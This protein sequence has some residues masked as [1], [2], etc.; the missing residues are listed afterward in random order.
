MET[1]KPNVLVQYG[2]MSG[3]VGLLFF[4]TLYLLGAKSFA[5]PVALLGYFIPIVFAVLACIKAKKNNNGFLEFP[6]ALR[7]SFGVFVISN[8]INTLALY[9]ILNVVD[10]DFRQALNQI[11]MEQTE[12]LLKKFNSSQDTIE[13]TL[14]EMAKSNQYSFGKMALGFAMYCIL[15]FLFSLIIAAIVKK[16]N[17]QEDMPQTL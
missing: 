8:L 3:V 7:T 12:L 5:S 6:K 15:W 4:I 10:E 1:N 14:T 9:L 11:A 17:P 13:R 16:K 2:L